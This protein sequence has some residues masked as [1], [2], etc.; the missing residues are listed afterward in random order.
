MPLNTRTTGAKK[1]PALAAAIAL[2][3]VAATLAG[4]ANR[5]EM[6]TGSL[7]DDYRTRHPIMIAEAERTIDIPVSSRDRRLTMGM[8]D[9]VRGFA[10][11]YNHSSSGV[12]QIIVPQ[13]SINAAAAASA[14]REIR[15]LLVDKGIPS[16]RILRASY[17]AGEAGDAAPVRLSFVAISAKT[18]QCGQWPEDM[19]SNTMENKNYY[20]FGCATQSNLAAQIANPMDL[21]APRDMSPIDAERRATVIGDYRTDG[22]G[23]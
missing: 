3:L 16:K 1:L 10:T 12:V 23:V 8:K 21:V 18:E 6:T 22:N 15:A 7:P 11:E 14:A 4:C 20:N 5:P 19:V 17:S 2:G 9:A 13:G